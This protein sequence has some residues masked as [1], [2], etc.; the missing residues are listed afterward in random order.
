VTHLILPYPPSTNRMWRIGNGRAYQSAEAKAFKALAA[1]QAKRA[2]LEL[3]TGP[4]EIIVILHPKK[5]KRPSARPVRCQDLDNVLK[6][7]I[8]ALQGIA[9]VN[10]SQIVSIRATKGDPVPCGALSVEVRAPKPS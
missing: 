3:R 2:K 8:D 4:V 5:P 10:D 9:Y 6:V 1:I 7:A